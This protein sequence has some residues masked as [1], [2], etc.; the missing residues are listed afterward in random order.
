MIC[1]MEFSSKINVFHSIPVDVIFDQ[2]PI[3]NCYHFPG[4]ADLC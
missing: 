2:S 4:M 3:C 1:H